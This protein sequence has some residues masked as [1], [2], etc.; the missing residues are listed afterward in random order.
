MIS[1]S[2]KSRMMRALAKKWGVPFI[3]LPA[4]EIG[5]YLAK[6]ELNVRRVLRGP[7]HRRV[8]YAHTR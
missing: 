8:R 3:S 5:E 2:R 7:K 6:G 1:R 4:R